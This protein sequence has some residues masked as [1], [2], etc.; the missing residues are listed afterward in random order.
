MSRNIQSYSD[1]SFNN[2]FNSYEEEF[3]YVQY[4]TEDIYD[5][6]IA[7]NYNGNTWREFYF[8]FLENKINKKPDDAC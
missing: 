8:A 4:E 5:D 3:F 6:E 2:P 1:F 7:I